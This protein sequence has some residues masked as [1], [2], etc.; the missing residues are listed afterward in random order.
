MWQ[1]GLMLYARDMVSKWGILEIMQVL[2]RR[3]GQKK[4]LPPNRIDIPWNSVYFGKYILLLR[5]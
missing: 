3:T 1:I 2:R 4:A 5:L